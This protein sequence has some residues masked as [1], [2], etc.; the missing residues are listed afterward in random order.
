MMQ[1][2]LIS[3]NHIAACITLMKQFY[4]HS[5]FSSNR[6]ATMRFVSLKELDVEIFI[7]LEFF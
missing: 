7:Q 4:V 6:I 1:L 2:V 3:I 5:K